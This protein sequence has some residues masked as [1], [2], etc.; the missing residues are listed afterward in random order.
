M[1]T[2]MECHDVNSKL[3]EQCD[4]GCGDNMTNTGEQQSQPLQSGDNVQHMENDSKPELEEGE[5]EDSSS[6]CEE[7]DEENIQVEMDIEKGN[8]DDQ[9]LTQHANKDG[10]SGKKKKVRVIKRIIKVIR[11]KP[12]LE[13]Q[14]ASVV[15][16]EL[17]KKPRVSHQAKY[18]QDTNIPSD[19]MNVRIKTEPGLEQSTSCGTSP[20]SSSASKSI[21]KSSVHAKVKREPS[22]AATE[23]SDLAS[24]S[25]KSLNQ[26]EIL[27][28]EMRARAIK[29]MLKKQE[30][31][32]KH[33]DPKAKK[34][35][36]LKRKMTEN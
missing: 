31:K 20:R 13:G 12:K 18:R 11:K 30:E 36:K 8:T 1:E 34:R 29:A 15:S 25:E 6:E 19:Y 10:A 4:V 24:V 21:A 7:L 22:T 27:E 2:A 32:D 9:L 16:R 26:M 14:S 28:L 35:I 23:H 5:I 17:P 3:S 33:I